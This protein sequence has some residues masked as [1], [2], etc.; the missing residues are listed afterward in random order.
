MRVRQ[1]DFEAETTQTPDS[2]DRVRFARDLD[3]EGTGHRYLR[4]WH[5]IWTRTSV[6]ALD[7]SMANMS[8]SRLVPGSPAPRLPTVE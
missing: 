3:H 6:P 5:T 4:R 8:T 7:E 1:S 2:K